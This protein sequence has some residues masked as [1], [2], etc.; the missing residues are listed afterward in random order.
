MTRIYFIAVAAL[1][2]LQQVSADYEVWA[3]DQSNSVAGESALGVKGSFLWVFSSDEIEK[4]VEGLTEQAKSEPC[5]PDATEGPCDLLEIFPQDLTASFANGTTAGELRDLDSFARFHYARPDASNN[6]VLINMFMP[7]GGYIG[8][9]DSRTK[10]AVALFRVT[11]FQYATD[12]A[13]STAETRSVHMSD[14]GGVDSSYIMIN[15]LH[16]KAVERI[17]VLRDENGDITGLDFDRSAS[18]GLGSK[19]KVS[20]E[21]TVF[22][23]SNVFGN[24]LIGSIIGD[25]ADA[26][27]SDATP[28][29]YCKENGCSDLAN[30]GAGGRGKNMPICT[31]TSANNFVYITLAGGGLFVADISET[32]LKI[33]AEYGKEV[34][35]GAGLCGVATPDGQVFVNSGVSASAAGKDQSMFA[36]W[37]FDDEAYVDAD[38]L[39]EN[40]PMPTLVYQDEATNTKTGGNTMGADVADTTGQ[41]PGQS[42][43]RD[44]HGMAVSVDGNYVQ[45]VDRI[46]NVIEV[47]DVFSLE[48]TTYDLTSEGGEDRYDGEAGACLAKSVDDDSG[49]PANDPAPD[50]ISTTPDGKYMVVG[51]RG[52]APVTVNHAAQGSCPGV[53]IVQPT[54]DGK[55]GKLISVIRT[56]NTIEDT[57]E[58]VPA[59]GGHEYTGKERSD[60]HGILVVN[61]DSNK[62]AN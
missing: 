36:V 15:N 8:V 14:W 54:K 43:R 11:K 22:S 39:C 34:I 7:G 40:D 12:G 24:A 21:A 6:Y 16:G 60:I 1:A 62:G 3:V 47:F 29:G 18:L 41:L 50:P 57:L 52:P 4:Q 2:L 37:S 28:N 5:T 58:T 26:D 10:E 20:E 31:L 9:V 61:R 42:T 48:K 32:P 17:N 49:L 53:G 55:G 19:M 44:S 30:G 23:G 35:Y 13:G 33:V 25:Y 56:S 51:L 45:G 46:Q 27:L 59:P 38:S